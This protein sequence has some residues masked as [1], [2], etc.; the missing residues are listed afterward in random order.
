MA[1]KL[2]DVLVRV[3]T[4]ALAG[5]LLFH[6]PKMFFVILRGLT[7]WLEWSGFSA[8]DAEY[9]AALPAGLLAIL[10]ASFCVVIGMS[11]IFFGHGRA[12]LE[13]QTPPDQG[14]GQ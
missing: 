8:Y 13:P 3:L 1:G 7:A 14:E 5:S 2:T 9:Y 4:V 12:A 6:A 11:A 10:I